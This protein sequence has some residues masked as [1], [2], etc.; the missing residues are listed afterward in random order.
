MVETAIS[1]D[2]IANPDYT[3]A[4]VKGESMSPA[5][6]NGWSIDIARARP[7]D[8]KTGDIIIF[9]KKLL[10][11]HRLLFKARLFGRYYIIQKGDN[12]KTGSVITPEDIIGKVS[13]VFDE[14]GRRVDES[15]WRITHIGTRN[16]FF[17]AFIY[18]LVFLNALFLARA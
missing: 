14:N 15:I 9:R 16:A 3:F 6:K 4:G 2:F 7:E 18:L 12:A 8:I 10:I 13:A 11:C 1:S 5:V 17:T